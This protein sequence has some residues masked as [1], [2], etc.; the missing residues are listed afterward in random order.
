[1]QRVVQVL[2]LFLELL[3]GKQMPVNFHRG[4]IRGVAGINRNGKFLQVFA[5]GTILAKRDSLGNTNLD[6]ASTQN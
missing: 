6:G 4:L 5:A 3:G 1:L 2:E